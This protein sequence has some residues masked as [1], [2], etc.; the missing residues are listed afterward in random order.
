M[1]H[2]SNQFVNVDAPDHYQTGHLRGSPDHS[3]QEMSKRRGRAFI[4]QVGQ[5]LREGSKE[6][7]KGRND[8]SVRQEG[9]TGR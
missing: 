6:D 5:V 3:V 8:G 9:R 1:L 2:H 4:K 7:I